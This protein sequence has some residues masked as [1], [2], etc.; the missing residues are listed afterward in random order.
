[1]ALYFYNRFAKQRQ[2][3][4]TL[5]RF[6]GH[7]RFA[8]IH[9]FVFRAPYIHL[10]LYESVYSTSISPS[11][12]KIKVFKAELVNSSVVHCYP[13]CGVELPSLFLHFNFILD[14]RVLPSFNRTCILIWPNFRNW[15]SLQVAIFNTLRLGAHVRYIVCNENVALQRYLSV[16]AKEWCK[17][18]IPA[19]V[20]SSTVGRSKRD[21]LQPEPIEAP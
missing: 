4:G 19:R 2:F 15:A 18:D 9:G 8:D 3:P 6:L 11:Y 21:L 10:K 12:I 14:H 1:M 20:I 5:Q 13:A 17:R 7:A 16:C